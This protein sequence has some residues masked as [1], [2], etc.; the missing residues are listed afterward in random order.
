MKG[1]QVDKVHFLYMIEAMYILLH[2]SYEIV[3]FESDFPGVWQQKYFEEKVM[4]INAIL[5]GWSL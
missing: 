4:L 3:F 2:R 1:R 5:P